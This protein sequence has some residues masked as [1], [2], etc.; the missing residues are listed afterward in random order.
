MEKNR[1]IEKGRV[2]KI[3]IKDLRD[4]ARKEGMTG[5]S[6]RFIMKSLDSALSDSDKG[7]IT[8]ISIMESL[9]KQVKEQIVDEEFRNSCLESIQKVVREEYLKIL[10]TEIA[11]AFVTAYEEQHPTPEEQEWGARASEAKPLPL[12]LRYEDGEEIAV[13]RKER[14]MGDQVTDD[15]DS[16]HRGNA[17]H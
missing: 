9:T 11:K 12:P 15:T 17:E 14:Y 7:M 10:E 2:K 13:L 8:P 6:T 16:I 1:P 5:I 4:E 3:D